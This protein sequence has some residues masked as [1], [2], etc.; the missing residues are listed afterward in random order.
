MTI[1]SAS[2][3]SST[4]AR[5]TATVAKRKPTRVEGDD[6]RSDAQADACAEHA[7]LP[8]QLEAGELELELRE[9]ARVLGDLLRRGAD[10]GMLPQRRGWAWPLQSI[11]FASSVPTR[12]RGPGDDERVRAERGFF[13]GECCGRRALRHRRCRGRHEFQVAS[14]AVR[15]TWKVMHQDACRRPSAP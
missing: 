3:V 9:G 15:Q 14:P 1:S 11:S 6:G 5:A 4:S 12:E 7:R 10:A 8:L 13:G 2:Q